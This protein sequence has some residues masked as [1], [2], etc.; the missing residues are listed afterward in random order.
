MQLV[1]ITLPNGYEAA[2][3]WSRTVWLRPWR[4]ADEIAVLSADA[5]ALPPAARV[6]ALLARCVYVAEGARPAGRAFVRALAAG[7]RE[8]LLL[9]LRRITLGDCLS[10][11]LSCRACGNLMDLDLQVS[12]LLVA[13]SAAATSLHEAR[14]VTTSGSI[15]AWFRLPTG[16]DQ[17]EVVVLAR[18][19][20]ANA[21]RIVAERCINRIEDRATGAERPLSDDFIESIGEAMVERDP[22]A[23]ILLDAACPGCGARATTLFDAAAYIFQEMGR[24]VD[25]LLRQVHVLASHYHWSERH[26]LRLTARRRRTYLEL[27]ASA[28][29]PVWRRA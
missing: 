25:T 13:P 11:V 16:A 23:Q 9:H 28:H 18:R 10:C 3:E 6:T 14:I 4:G 27:I 5:A 7:D 20:P 21:A 24:H 15:R 26:I 17:E 1:P 22:Q 2:G 12:D 8:A 19:D 29:Q